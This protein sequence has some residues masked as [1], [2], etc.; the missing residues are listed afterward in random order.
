MGKGNRVLPLQPPHTSLYY[1]FFYLAIFFA[2]V[3]KLYWLYYALPYAIAN[4]ICYSVVAINRVSVDVGASRH[5]VYG[6]KRNFLTFAFV[7]FL[8][9]TSIQQSFDHVQ[10]LSLMDRVTLGFFLYSHCAVIL[11]LM[12][13]HDR[14]FAVHSA[15]RVCVGWV[16]E[17]HYSAVLFSLYIFPLFPLASS[18]VFLRLRH[19]NYSVVALY[20]IVYGYLLHSLLLSLTPTS[21]HKW[22]YFKI[23]RGAVREGPASVTVEPLKYNAYHVG[24][25]CDIAEKEKKGAVRVCQISD[26]HLDSSWTASALRRLCAHIVQ[27]DPDLVLLTGDFYFTKNDDIAKGLLFFALLPLKDISH[28]CYACL[29]NHDLK[30]MRSAKDIELCVSAELKRLGIR[31]LRNESV[32]HNERVEVIGFDFVKENTDNARSDMMKRVLSESKLAK[33]ASDATRVVLLHNPDHFD[34]FEGDEGVVVFGG[35]VH[36]GHVGFYALGSSWCHW[37][38][39]HS[40]C[41]MIYAKSVDYGVFRKGNN[42]LY[43]HRGNTLYSKA[44]LRFGVPAEQQTCILI[45]A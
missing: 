21:P 25:N 11:S 2:C 16:A 5:E 33:A 10:A 15:Y 37:L 12:R 34:D 43:V 3:S 41:R 4:G 9:Y 19:R 28:K 20:A 35:H 22:T 23:P 24:D 39:D 14:L 18:F 8:L 26:C 36:G 44:L 42:Y 29:G 30:T 32:L 27:L 38:R 1:L 13:F 45:N 17:L 6:Q 31:L 40:L 7:A